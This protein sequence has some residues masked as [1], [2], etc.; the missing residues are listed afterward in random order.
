MDN[1]PFRFLDSPGSVKRLCKTLAQV[2]LAAE[3]L[4]PDLDVEDRDGYEPVCWMFRCDW[5][6]DPIEL[7]WHYA[8]WPDGM[9]Q[10]L[11]E[12]TVV[13]QGM[14]HAKIQTSALQGGPL[15]DRIVEELAVKCAELTGKRPPKG[16]M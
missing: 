12:V 4:P 5:L 3:G 9:S 10:E 2:G 8:W 14:T 13:H 6:T 11:D 16:K 15:A 1:L 7:H